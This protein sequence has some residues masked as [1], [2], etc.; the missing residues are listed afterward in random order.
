[1]LVVV[2]DQGAEA[3]DSS[4]A[5]EAIFTSLGDLEQPNEKEYCSSVPILADG[6]QDA[7]TKREARTFKLVCYP[8][9]N[10]R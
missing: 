6:F 9:S 3:V 7:D 8:R 5:Q 4:E 1:M 2:E 10:P